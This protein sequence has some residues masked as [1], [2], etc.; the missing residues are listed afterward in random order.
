M[1]K[2]KEINKGKA[3][4]LQFENDGTRIEVFKATR[5]GFLFFSSGTKK[6]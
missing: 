3:L 6:P 2:K 4:I 1:F 5:F